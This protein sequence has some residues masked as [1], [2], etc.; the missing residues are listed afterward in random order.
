MD[1]FP[2]WL[3]QT[4][5][6]VVGIAGYRTVTGPIKDVHGNDLANGRLR[7][8][9]I[10]PVVAGTTF[11]AP[12]GVDEPIVDGQVAI[13]LAAPGK[14][15]FLVVDQYGETL[16]S[17]QAVVTD[18]TDA[19]IS[20]AELYL[21]R[22][23]NDCPMTEGDFVPTTFTSLLDTPN[24]L[25]GSAG[26]LLVVGDDEDDVQVSPRMLWGSGDPEGVVTADVGTIF[27]REDGSPGATM[28]LKESGSGTSA[29]WVAK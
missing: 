17:F 21:S 24:S 25:I 8:N 19:A 2:D 28:Y 5:S 6:S 12:A 14:Y 9:P 11:V 18:D 23:S 3:G 4:G 16:W 22:D 29:G 27:I 10:F 20:L 13:P 1:I 26:K 15:G 7:I